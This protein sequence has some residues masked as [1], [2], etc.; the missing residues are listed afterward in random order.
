MA[1]LAKPFDPLGFLSP[2]IMF[3]K[4]IMQ[5]IW[6]LG[7]GW[8]DELPDTI[9]NKINIWIDSTKYFN[10]WCIP[11]IYFFDIGWDA[12]NN[13]EVHGFCDASLDGYGTVVYL[14]IFANNIYQV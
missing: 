12:I 10:E 4:I 1:L 6:R 13:I 5:L 3:G 8:D 14:R 11:R 9:K 2:F 7:L